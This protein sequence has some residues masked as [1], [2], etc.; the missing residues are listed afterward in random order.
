M[1]MEVNK[2]NE[3]PAPAP[4]PVDQRAAMY[5]QIAENHARLV[6]VLERSGYGLKI[7]D[8]NS[9]QLQLGL[10]FFIHLEHSIQFLAGEIMGIRAFLRKQC[11]SSTD[12]MDPNL[13]EG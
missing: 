10:S 8:P 12:G 13:Q 7:K 11:E 4:P 5:Q 3:V 1:I 9:P 2:A 6:M